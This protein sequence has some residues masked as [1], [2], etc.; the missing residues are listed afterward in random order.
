MIFSTLTIAFGILTTQFNLRFFMPLWAV[1]LAI[2]LISKERRT[3]SQAID[4]N[5]ILLQI[6]VVGFLFS[7]FNLY[8][9]SS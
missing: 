8:S 5:K 2:T 1:M 4:D 6:I 9:K 7:V 3:I